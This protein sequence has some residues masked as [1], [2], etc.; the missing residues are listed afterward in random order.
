MYELKRRKPI[1]L[2]LKVGDKILDVVID[3][4]AILREYNSCKTKLIALQAEREQVLADPASL[5]DYEVEYGKAIYALTELLLGTENTK[6]I[7][8]FYENRYVEMVEDVIGFLVEEIMPTLDA[9]L[10]EKR[11]RMGQMY[12]ARTRTGI[13][14]SIKGFARWPR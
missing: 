3:P 1:T 14:G 13:G 4:Q 8:E 6:L 11:K 2:Q 5:D 7:L 9:A 10:A 12:T